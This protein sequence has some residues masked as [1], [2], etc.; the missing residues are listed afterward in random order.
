MKRIAY[1]DRLRV[2]SILAV[3]L[4]HTSAI[5]HGTLNSRSIA[6]QTLNLY[7]SISRWCVPVLIM[8]SGALFLSRKIS[9]K[10][11]Y[12]KNIARLCS[13]FFVWSLF[14]NALIP[15]VKA[16]ISPETSVTISEIIKNVIIGSTHLWFLPMIIGLYMCIPFFQKVT[17][18]EML[19][20]YFLLLSFVFTFCIPQLVNLA[21]DFPEIFPLSVISGMEELVERMH[22]DTVFGYSFYFIL[23]Y[24]LNRREFSKKQQHILL[25]SGGAGFL[26]TIL[27]NG[28]AA[29]KTGQPCSTYYSNFSIN[30]LFEAVGIFI[31]CKYPPY[32]FLVPDQVFSRLSGYSFG[33]YLVHVAFLRLFPHFGIDTLWIHPLIAVPVI[34]ILVSVLSFFTSFVLNH[35]P[36]IKKW[37]A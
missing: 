19:M 34:A 11:I 31:F 36:Y 6:W 4:L 15:V 17:E 24:F 33:A 7:N 20:K 16:F 23:G 25:L 1:F 5:N 30:V 2:L 9:L 14:Y 21:S 18:D 27:L 10:T 3:I 32:R 29:W 12:Q 22:M 37:I 13:A 35:I 28:L 26:L 8:I